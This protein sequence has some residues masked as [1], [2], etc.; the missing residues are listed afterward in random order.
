ML[1]RTNPTTNIAGNTFPRP[2][3][4]LVMG[5]VVPTPLLDVGQPQCI[6]VSPHQ[7]S[8]LYWFYLPPLKC[9]GMHM[10]AYWP[11]VTHGQHK[12]P[13][14]LLGVVAKCPILIDV[15]GVVI[16]KGDKL[17]EFLTFRGISWIH[18][19]LVQ[20]GPTKSSQL[21]WN[22]PHNKLDFVQIWWEC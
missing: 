12:K 19:H 18:V 10:S 7:W 2:T 15:S 20:I 9:Q 17:L 14:D 6:A 8:P 1:P 3:Y 13:S 5:S 21:R 4:P 11:C 16:H 22:P